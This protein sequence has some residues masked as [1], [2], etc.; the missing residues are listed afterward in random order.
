[1]LPFEEN[2]DLR[3]KMSQFFTSNVRVGRILELMDYIASNV[4][5]RYCSASSGYNEDVLKLP[6]ITVTAAIDEIDFF[7]PILSQLNCSFE[8]YVTYVGRSSMEIQIVVK[9]QVEGT[10]RLACS[11]KFVMVARDKL[12]N[13]AYSVPPLFIAEDDHSA[14]IRAELGEKRQ[15]IRKEE[16]AK[17]LNI[18]PP[19]YEESTAVH[20]LLLR[21]NELPPK[22]NLSIG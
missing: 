3:N 15:R 19:T 22:S 10:E 14:L 17:A 4:A 20:K 12:T 6:F 1:M 13:K 18:S 16:A 11:A 7:H 9:Q 5:Y 8:G 2:E 21:I